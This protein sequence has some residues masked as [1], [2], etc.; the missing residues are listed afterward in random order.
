MLAKIS[1][2]A[3]ATGQYAGFCSCYSTGKPEK[4]QADNY[5]LFYLIP[6]NPVV[7]LSLF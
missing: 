1:H 3:N 2:S 5:N 6:A 7:L 4:M